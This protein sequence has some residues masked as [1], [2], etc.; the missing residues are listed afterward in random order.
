MK[1]IKKINVRI[2][3]RKDRCQFGLTFHTREIR[4]TKLKKNYKAIPTNPILKG[5][6]LKKEHQFQKRNKKKTETTKNIRIKSNI[7]IK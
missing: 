5:K 2:Y 1:F 4:I 7:K 3:Y 6:K